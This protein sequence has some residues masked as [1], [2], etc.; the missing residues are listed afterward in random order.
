MSSIT[1]HR[2]TSQGE[3]DVEWGKD[4]KGPYIKSGTFAKS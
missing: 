3:V 1:F 4:G 2:D